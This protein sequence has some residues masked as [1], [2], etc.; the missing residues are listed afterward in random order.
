MYRFSFFPPIIRIGPLSGQIHPSGVSNLFQCHTILYFRML[1]VWL[2]K[3]ST[4]WRIHTM[5]KDEKIAEG[6]SQ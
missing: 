4:E 1:M 3:G 6:M 5:I 2:L